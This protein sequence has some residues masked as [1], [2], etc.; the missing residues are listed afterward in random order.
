ML[1]MVWLLAG[2]SV[3]LAEQYTITTVAGGAPLSTPA[4]ATSSGIGRPNRVTLDSSGNVY[5]SSS[6]NCVFKLSTSGVLALVA[7]NS[8][9]G[10]AGDGGPAT[11]AMLNSP[12]GLAL[13][14]RGNLYI[15]DSLNN[16]VRMVNPQGIISTFAGTGQFSQDSSPGTFNDG[17]PATQGLLHNPMGVAVDSSGNV[18]IADTGHNLVR[19]VTT[20]G[21]IITIAGDG[22]PSYYGDPTTTDDPIPPSPATSAELHSPEDVA[23]DSAGTVYI[24]DTANGR[25]REIVSGNISTYAGSSTIGY[26]GDGDLATDAELFAPY[27][28]AVDSSKNVYIVDI[29]NSRVRE[30]TVSDGYI[31]TVV[32]NGYGNFAGDGSS[33]VKASLNSPTGIAVDSSGNMYIADSQSLRVRKAAKGGNITTIAGNGIYA[34][35]G[36]NGQATSAQFNSPRAVAADAGGNLYI[37]DSAN[38]VVRIVYTNGAI[39]NV[40]GNGAASQL[41]LP[42]GLAVDSSGNLYVAD[43]Q[44]ARVQKVSPGGAVSIVAGNGTS[45]YAGDGGQATSAQLNTPMGLAVDGTG[46]LY[47]SDFSNNRVRMVSPSGVITTVAGNGLTGYS[48][49]GG[50]AASARLTSPVGLAVDSAN[51]LYIADSGNNVIRKVAP[52]GVISTVA[53]NGLPGYSGDGGP[54]LR[55]QLV[56]PYG[57]AVDSVGNLYISDFNGRVRKTYPDGTIATI[58]GTGTQGYTGDGGLATSARLNRPAGLAMGP[59]GTIYIADA[60]NGAV[61]GLQSSGAGVSLAAVVNGASGGTG[62]VA[63]GEVVVLWGS[64][65]GPGALTQYSLTSAG[66]VPTSLAGTSVFFNGVPA[67]VLYTSATQV[68]AIVPFGTTGSS[69]QVFVLY[70]GQNSAPLTAPVAETAPALFTLNGS[71]SGPALAINV[72]DGSINGAAHPANSGSYVTL[73]ATGAGQT[74]PGGADGQPVTGLPYPVPNASVTATIGGQSAKVNYAGGALNLVAGVIQVNVQVPSGLSAGAVPIAL[75]IGGLSTQSGATIVVSGK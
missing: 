69:A 37:A 51:N 53:G 13:D 26:D 71:G 40:L 18:Y 70:Q 8:R 67:P 20:D 52:G 75:Q 62:A 6:T 7:G 3:A 29:E 21:N 61:R 10:F 66:L 33:A 24:A 74:N 59:G 19:E 36:D 64:G 4:T 15:A 1:R 54:A 5:F 50:Q 42:G 49:D 38:N 35:S 46:N 12:Q 34:Y 48:G 22:Y 47:I 30:V 57:I 63:P 31:N 60:A 65:L 43:S 14:A 9:A 17:G 44:N 32:G 11:S 55:A 27:A 39:Y 45:G 58:A 2:A 72:A 25:V 23:V 41:N 28:L 73:Y 16:R 56:N 68:G